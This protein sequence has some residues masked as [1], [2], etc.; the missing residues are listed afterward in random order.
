MSLVDAA[1][2]FDLCGALPSGVTV[3]EASAGTGKT[4]TIAALATRYV[5]AGTPLDRLLIVTFTRAAA[6]ELRE[7][8]RERLVT[9]REALDGALDG[10][11]PAERDRVAVLLAAGTPA[12][13]ALRR[14]RLAAALAGFDAATITTT[15][16][17]C[18]E[19]LHALG[20]AGDLDGRYAFNAD[21]RDLTEEVL[22][23]W[24]VEAFLHRSPAF[25]RQ[26]ALDIALKA[27]RNPTVK[28]APPATL[29]DEQE[30]EHYR[31]LL[32]RARLRQELA[33][34]VRRELD[35]RKRA[36]ALMTY[37]DLLIRLRAAL[38]GSQGPDV[39]TR[40]RARH[41][42]VMVDEFQD[43]DLDQW[44]ILRM[45]FLDGGRTLV[46]IGDPKQAIYGFRGA[47]VHAY[48]DARRSA[49]AR[50][51]L[52]VNR[53]S[54]QPLIDAY[55]ALFAGAE[56]G[57]PDIVYRDVRAVEAN[58]AP[59]M[60]GAPVTA[61]LRIRVVPRE[62]PAIE[63]SDKT[64]CATPKS[65][66]P[67]IARDV[68]ADIVELL[69]SGATIEQR[70]EDGAPIGHE[71][72]QPGHLAVLVRKNAQL[73]LIKEALEAVGVPAVVNG[74]GSVFA[75]DAARDWLALLEA[76]EQPETQARVRAAALTPFLGWSAERLA[77]TDDDGW[78]EVQQVLHR[79]TAILRR[80]GIATLTE[81]ITA[82]QQLPGRVLAHLGGERVLTDLRH[83]SELLHA[84]VREEQFGITALVAWLRRRIA[85]A[86][87]EHD[88]ESASERSRRLESDAAAVQ[89]LTVHRSKGL[90]F[91][92][93]YCPYLWDPVWIPFGNRPA[94]FHDKDDGE[95]RTLD[96]AMEDLEDYAAHLELDQ[97]EQ[98][99]EELRLAYVALTR[100]RH[101]AVVWWV[102]TSFSRNSALSRLVIGRQ[103]GSPALAD[104][105]A[106]PSDRAA[107][108][109]FAA[110]KP[111]AIAVERAN[112][113]TVAPWQAPASTPAALEVATL[114][115]ALDQRWRRT[116]YS[117]IVDGAYEARVASEI[118]EAIGADDDPQ[119]ARSAG[120]LV[121]AVGDAADALKAVPSL[122][123]DTPASTRFGT[124][125]HRVLERVDFAA[126]DLD[127][128]LGR[129]IADG[130]DRRRIDVGDPGRLAT[131]LRSAIETPL[132][133][134]VGGRRLRDLAP[135][136]R[137]DE[138]AFDLPLVGGDV[139]TGELTLAAI[140]SVL[141]EG[142]SPEDPLAGYAERLADP[143][144]RTTL[145]GYL[146]GTIDL[147]ARFGTP[148][149]PSFAIVDYKTNRLGGPREPLTAWHYRPS[150][151][152][153]EM[154]HSHYALQA[155][156]Y[157][158][159]LHRF[160]RWRMPDYDAERDRPA[161]LYL[162]LRGMTGEATPVVDGAP[163]GL[164]AWR[165][166]VGLVG[167]L[168]DVLDRGG[169]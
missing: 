96:V 69:R 139:P 28:I 63:V 136:D 150:M 94:I 105:T 11:A 118:E 58:R 44:A 27:V 108:I 61:P 65:A 104:G 167:T 168:S 157:A 17:F 18:Q 25:N 14:D 31:A 125:A 66:R 2:E 156:L 4:Y 131:G 42:V 76:L 93:V 143:A 152:A 120:G 135:A 62:D 95:V 79:W 160:L 38:E 64:G 100:A 133:P 10:R 43:T 75:T 29:D 50:P 24:Y 124:F 163:C 130:V 140:A 92:I 37:D 99:G 49:S 101:Q 98:L 46:L 68:A 7:R 113:R 119:L 48:L 158:V 70:D 40:M 71:T 52:R 53:R 151:L 78:D 22:D 80:S 154:Q 16:G 21:A 86:A 123:S 12:E 6:G 112:P 165:P 147:V 132:G 149:A 153:A 45:A 13:V 41:H 39:A 60:A 144:L 1:E 97:S 36:A 102:G 164:F 26:E 111:G 146:T 155:L 127:R 74:A 126:D 3:L 103:E 129:E 47:D 88:D 89:I 54:D 107:F 57:H 116:S 32:E 117:A 90:E 5:A 159:A 72:M 141:R 34:D 142:V 162:F 81:T 134:L 82:D 15:H 109:A 110:L 91:P 115:R 30:G 138:L 114:G 83:V 20:M 166:P 59:R 8:V 56:L 9:A 51:T 148:D 121:A 137:L 77:G 128:D 84:A 145:R 169:P 106:T 161:I 35:R 85:L 73:S 19:E 55:D 87:Q 23:D 33:E 67:Y 122:L